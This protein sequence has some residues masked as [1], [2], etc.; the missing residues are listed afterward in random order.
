MS[1]VMSV[2]HGYA[3]RYGRWK[4]VAGGI[5]CVAKHAT[6]DCSKPQLYDMVNDYAENHDLSGEYP[7]VHGIDL[8]QH[9]AW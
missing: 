6:F 9:I 2:E 5:S 3:Y 1:P 4:L 7:E 8:C